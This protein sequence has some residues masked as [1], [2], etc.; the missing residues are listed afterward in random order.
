MEKSLDFQQSIIQYLD[1]LYENEDKRLE[2]IESKVSQLIAQ[3]GIVISL[4]SFLI[5]LMYD[6]LLEANCIFKILLFMTFMLMLFYL[7]KSIFEASKIQKVSSF[8]YMD[9]SPM[10]IDQVFDSHEKFNAEYISDLRKSIEN[11]KKVNNKKAEILMN[12]NRFFIYGI[13]CVMFLSAILMINYYF[14]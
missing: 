10:T 13:F 11:N 14:S 3:S 4:I 1:R 6:K 12:A 7:G 8:R 9:C 2:I 5:P